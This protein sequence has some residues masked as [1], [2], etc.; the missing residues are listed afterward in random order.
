[1]MRRTVA[2]AVQ[3]AAVAS[4]GMLLAGGCFNATTVQSVFAE[5]V[6]FT[7]ANIAQLLSLNFLS[8]LLA[9]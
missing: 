6:A 2:R 4:G 1:M 5:N 8:G 7:A 3:W 9:T